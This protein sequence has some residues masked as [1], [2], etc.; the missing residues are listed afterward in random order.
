M[1]LNVANP[2]SLFL[3]HASLQIYPETVGKIYIQFY[4][5]FQLYTWNY[6]LLFDNEWN[7][8]YIAQASLT[9][10]ANANSM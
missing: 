8:Y 10:S 7:I 5:H 2:I 1:F 6:E 3:V 4:L 9:F